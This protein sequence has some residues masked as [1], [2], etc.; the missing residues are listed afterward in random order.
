MY[1]MGKLVPRKYGVAL[2][3]WAEV[4]RGRSGGGR[5]KEREREKERWREREKWR[6]REQDGERERWKGGG[7]G[8]CP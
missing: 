8:I 2:Q 5:G 4:V 6:E 1:T 7:R 3:S